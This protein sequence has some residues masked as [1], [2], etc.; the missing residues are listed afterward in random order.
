MLDEGDGIP[1]D[2]NKAVRW[3]WVAA[4]RGNAQA[5]FKI[6]LKFDT[7]DGLPADAGQAT[8][9]YYEAA[10]Q[11]HAEACN[12]LGRCFAM[13]EGVERSD[14]EAFRWFDIAAELGVANAAKYRERVARE[15]TS[16]QRIRAGKLSKEWLVELRSRSA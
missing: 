13:G 12:N 15:L 16:E 14:I 11:G 1:Q 6:G 8:K 10:K 3:Y 2:E 9:W 4:E 5:Q 7:G